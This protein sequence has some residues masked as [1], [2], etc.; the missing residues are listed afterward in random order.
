MYIEYPNFFGIIEKCIRDVI[1][2]AHEKGA[3]VVIYSNPL[4][5][6]IFKPPGELGA[7]IVVGDTQPLGNGLNFGGPT[8]GIIGIKDRRDLLRQLPGRLI[9][10]TRD[11]EGRL[12]YMMILQ[13]REQH[14]RRERATSNIT[15]NSSLMAIASLVYIALLGRS[16]LKELG[17]AILGR[18][19]YAISRFKELK[20]IVKVPAIGSDNSVLFRE[21]TVE[22]IG[23]DADSII[24]SLIRK[25]IHIGP[26]LSKFFK[27]FRS[28]SIICVTEAHC[29]DDIDQLI[30]AVKEILS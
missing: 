10:A 15:T 19:Y 5:L 12:G 9:G 16:G 26:P 4:A 17:E 18:T 13:T 8:A 1:D 7:D 6:G 3:L 30:Q 11:C 28:T 20:D 2:L 24:K 29:K 22:F 25:N 21:F 27:E 14:I 23:R